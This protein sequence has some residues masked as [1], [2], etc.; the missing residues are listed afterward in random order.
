MQKKQTN[1][2]ILLVGNGKT[3]ISI[4]LCL[5]K[6]GERVVLLTKDIESSRE[7]FSQL[8]AGLP[9]WKRTT[10]ASRLTLIS[11]IQDIESVALA[12]AYT[13]ESESEKMEFIDLLERNIPEDAIIGINTESIP[14]HTIQEHARQPQRVM[15]V[16]WVEPAHANFFL[17]IICNKAVQPDAAEQLLAHANEEWD[18]DG[19]I[20]YSDLGIR[21]KLFSAMVR[22]ALYLVGHEFASIE[23][24][25][26]ACRN[27]GGYYLPFAGNLRY[28]D[29][30]G[31]QSYGM[32]MEGLNPELNNDESLPDFIKE[33][34]KQKKTGMERNMGFYEYE[35]G[36]AEDWAKLVNTFSLE[37]Q[38]LMRSY[39][40]D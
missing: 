27:D 17:E 5:C 6:A 23:D 2:C 20:V 28:M 37:I 16:N 30:M 18:K 29:L 8:L 3:L 11:R 21:A 9:D 7:Q 38:E 24:I 36:S 26:R 35:E 31:T 12:I 10:I 1:K 14:L 22:E 40:L 33:M 13:N 4:A 34:E 39:R 32:V 25:D 19:Y 15:G